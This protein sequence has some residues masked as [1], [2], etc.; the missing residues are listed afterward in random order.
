MAVR[1]RLRTEKIRI[2]LFWNPPPPPPPYPT[3]RFLSFAFIFYSLLLFLLFLPYSLFH[4][5]KF[6]FLA[7]FLSFTSPPI[8]FSSHPP[9][10]SHSFSLQVPS[11]ISDP[12]AYSR[13]DIFF[14][15]FCRSFHICYFIIVLKFY[16]STFLPYP[17]LSPFFTHLFFK[18][19]R[20]KTFFYRS[21]ILQLF[22]NVVLLAL[23]KQ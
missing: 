4:S 15:Y 16:S 12:P 1:E 19:R 23:L 7:Y 6:F 13:S 17:T 2:K 14:L 20:Q 10:T 3:L 22:L 18:E 8:S 9:N 5:S 21:N 11:L